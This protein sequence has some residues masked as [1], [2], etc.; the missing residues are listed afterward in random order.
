[1]AKDVQTFFSNSGPLALSFSHYQPRN[2]QLEMSCMIE[3]LFQSK[4]FNCIEA[5]TGIGKTFAY[6]VPSLFQV[7]KHKQKIVISTHTIALQ[8]QLFYKDIPFL[9]DLL[10]LDIEVVLVKGMN[11]YLCLEKL[12]KLK[13]EPQFFKNPF[14]EELSQKIQNDENLNEE[15]IASSTPKELWH[16]LS[17][18]SLSCL[19]HTCPSYKN[20]HFFNARKPLEQASILIV[21]HHLL[22]TDLAIKNDGKETSILPASHHLIIDEAHHIAD[23][24]EELFSHELNQS[25]LEPR[26][27]PRILKEHLEILIRVFRDLHEEELLFFCETEIHESIDKTLRTLFTAFDLTL[28]SL[29][30]SSNYRLIKDEDGDLFALFDEATFELKNL[31]TSLDHLLKAAKDH[32]IHEKYRT[33]LFVVDKLYNETRQILEV[34]AAFKGLKKDK[35]FFYEKKTYSASF[36]CH[37]I[38]ASKQLANLLSSHYLSTTFCSATLTFDLNFEAFK[39]DCGLSFDKYKV[40]E[41]RFFSDFN[42]KQA[43]LFAIPSDIPE[44]HHKD[45]ESKLYEFCYETIKATQGGVFILFTSYDQLYKMSDKLKTSDVLKNISLFVQGTDS[46][47]NL[48]EGFKSQNNSVLLGTDS[49]W[50]GVDVQGE[51]LRCVIITKLPFRSPN[52]PIYQATAERLKDEKKDPFFEKTLPEACIKFKQGLGRLIRSKE[53]YG[54]VV[55]TDMRL[56]NKFYGKFFLKT[57]PNCQ[58]KLAPTNE[59]LKAIAAKMK[60]PIIK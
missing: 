51:K 45:Y 58:K 18:D 55:C 1:M 39:R 36:K 57:L 59:V 60:E 12:E 15:T 30:P 38:N 43:M 7:S 19:S 17:A 53:D 47:Q 46:K 9:L 48:L 2:S 20:C 35:L 5:E 22:L 26:L 31:S 49:F 41:A 40:H 21:N 3:K 8:E 6:L 4:G 34:L 27:R 56:I 52:D 13:N 32:Q 37:Y 10:K 54:V 42:Y 25:S 24:A 29:D 28:N 16:K 11:N 44:P 50:E 14:I 23:I 33:S